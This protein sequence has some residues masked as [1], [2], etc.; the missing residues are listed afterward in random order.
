MHYLAFNCR[1]WKDSECFTLI[2]LSENEPFFYLGGKTAGRELKKARMDKEDDAQIT[3]KH[4]EDDEI[5]CTENTIV[6]LSL[7]VQELFKISLTDFL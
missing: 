6:F 2:S 4:S 1:K 5:P 7:F 3:H